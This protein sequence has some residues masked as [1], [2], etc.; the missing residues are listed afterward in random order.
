MSNGNSNGNSNK[1]V[2]VV[3]YD[4]DIAKQIAELHRSAGDEVVTTSRNGVGD[5]TLELV[6]PQTWPRYV[7]EFDLL[8]YCIGAGDQRLSRMEVMQVNAFL[9][10]DYLT[11]VLKYLKPEAKIVVLTTAWG[12]VSNVLEIPI[13]RAQTNMAYKMSRAALNMGVAMLSRRFNSFTW[14]LM[15][16]GLVDTKATRNWAVNDKIS[17]AESAAGVVQHAETCTAGTLHFIDHR[18][19]T[20]SF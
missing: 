9:A 6:H 12:S 20:L 7:E 5:Y 1:T 17:P 13:A 11:S 4:S 10:C 3:G 15:H 14:V 18:G 8:Y 19:R 16:P 2:L